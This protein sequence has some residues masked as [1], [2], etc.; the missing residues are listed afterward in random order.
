M[1]KLDRRE[2]QIICE[3]NKQSVWTVLCFVGLALTLLAI[4]ICLSFSIIFGGL[5]FSVGV[6]L[7]IFSV[8]KQL[9][10]IANFSAKMALKRGIEH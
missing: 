1:Y 10:N 3:Y 9:T 5:L 2:Q 7:M 6:G 4:A 8:D